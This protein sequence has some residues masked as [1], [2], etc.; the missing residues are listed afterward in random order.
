MNR[1]NKS[2]ILGLGGWSDRT[3]WPLNWIKTVVET[4]VLGF[5]VNNSYKDILHKNWSLQLSKFTSTLHSWSSRIIDSI[6]QR[7]EVVTVFA[8]S[9][10]WYRGTVLPLPEKFAILF[11][12][13]ISKFLWKGNIVRNVLSKATVSLPKNKGGL[14]LPCI[15]LKCR[16]LF[17]RQIFR[18]LHNGNRDCKHYDFWIGNRL[19][20]PNLVSTGF[21]SK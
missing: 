18:T 2:V 15:R 13:E 17:M 10:V 16:S 20:L 8:L 19:N 3:I 4:K 12:K 14:G 9:K 5:I 1:C 6:Y 21:L 7:A 11:E